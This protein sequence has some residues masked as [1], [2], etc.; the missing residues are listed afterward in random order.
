MSM[1][2]VRSSMATMWA[3]RFLHRAR[4]SASPFWMMVKGFPFAKNRVFAL[5]RIFPVNCLTAA[6]PGMISIQPSSTACWMRS[7]PN[8]NRLMCSG[9]ST[10]SAYTDWGMTKE[11]PPS[12]PSPFSRRVR[13][14]SEIEIIVEES[15]TSFCA[16]LSLEHFPQRFQPRRDAEGDA[17]LVVHAR[18][19]NVVLHVLFFRPRQVHGLA[20]AQAQAIG[21]G[22]HLEARLFLHADGV[23]PELVV[24]FRDHFDDGVQA[25]AELLGLAARQAVGR[26]I[27]FAQDF[28]LDGRP[29]VVDD[30]VPLGDQLVQGIA[31]EGQVGVAPVVHHGRALEAGLAALLQCNRVLY[32]ERRPQVL[33]FLFKVPQCHV[34]PPPLTQSKN[35]RVAA[36][37]FNGSAVKGQGARARRKRMLV[38][39]LLPSCVGA[40]ASWDRR[41]CRCRLCARRRASETS[42]AGNLGGR[43]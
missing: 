2:V 3:R 11:T 22:S 19:A 42:L 23:P 33:D 30:D 6:L 40:G 32:L 41:N 35:L 37:R 15:K 28:G 27:Q 24:D 34:L 17:F 26:Q 20:E 9:R 13:H 8:S 4:V 36:Q 31:D 21:G 25:L 29:L 38:G 1:R 39:R 10:V 18:P 16:M 43:R 12:W 5:S 14:F 7:A